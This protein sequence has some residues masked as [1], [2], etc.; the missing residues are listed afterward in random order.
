MAERRIGPAE[1]GLAIG[2]N[3]KTVSRWA[4][5]GKIPSTWTLGG[6]RRFLLSEVRAALSELAEAKGEVVP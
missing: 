4:A 6:H 5:T 2:V 1:V 3:A